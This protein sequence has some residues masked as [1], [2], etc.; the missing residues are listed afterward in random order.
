MK[1]KTNPEKFILDACCGGRMFWF[2][3]HHPN[4]IYID[5]R[6]TKE[7]FNNY[8]T[9]RVIPDEVG[10]FRKLRFK[11][12]SFKLVIFDPPHLITNCVT[13]AITKA[14]GNLIPETWQSDIK[15][16]FN[17][18]WRVLD[19]FGVLIF[20]WSEVNVKRKELLRLIGKEPLIGHKVGAKLNTNWFCFMKIPIAETETQGGQE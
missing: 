16:G 13:G 2:N 4:C 6:I 17:E 12:K 9:H 20:K 11:D 7:G 5:K 1:E 8:E 18:C 19:D 15:R 10:D 3:K 14:Y